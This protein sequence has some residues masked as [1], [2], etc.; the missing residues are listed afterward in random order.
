[1]KGGH[2][3][4]LSQIDLAFC[5]DLTRSMTGFIQ[6]ARAHMLDV[7]TALTRSAD[8]N[9][10]VALVGYR[11]YGGRTKLVEAYPFTGKQ[12]DTRHVLNGLQVDSPQENTDAAEAVF[13]GLSAC[14][15][16][17]AWRPAAAKIV[18][19]VG[20]APPHGCGAN[21]TPCPDRYPR[22]D[23][24]G[25]TLMSMSS[26]TE[27]AGV[28]LYALGMVP[29]ILPAYDP[30]M[31][32]SFTWLAT[33]TGGTYRPARSSQDALG[34]VEAIGRRVFG[35]LDFDRR[36]WAQL[37]QDEPGALP[38]AGQLETML[39]AAQQALGASPYEIHAAVERLRKRALPR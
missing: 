2:M 28:V 35:Q 33:T 13:A 23:P 7:L 27:A 11:D 1:M 6:A 36:V 9:L 15:D 14:L 39:P 32:K 29:S 4:E 20:D 31:E 24:S 12:A 3:D 17:L 26:R 21:A 18:L 38:A 5:V 19:L 8:A 30:V 25:Q 10:R 16:E 22:G 37:T 34:V